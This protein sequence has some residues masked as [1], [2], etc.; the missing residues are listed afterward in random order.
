MLSD[1]TLDLLI[2]KK[3]IK[4]HDLPTFFKKDYKKGLCKVV[5]Y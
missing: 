2:D 4:L 5:R 3:E 1:D